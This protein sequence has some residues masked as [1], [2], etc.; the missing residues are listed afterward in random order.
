MNVRRIVFENHFTIP[1]MATA[2]RKYIRS[3]IVRD[4]FGP[5]QQSVLMMTLKMAV[6]DIANTLENRCD[7]RR[8]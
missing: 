3:P 6:E 2:R 5:E 1:S 8:M 7:G 4:N